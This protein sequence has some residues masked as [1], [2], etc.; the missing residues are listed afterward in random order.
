MAFVWVIR[1][2]CGLTDSRGHLSSTFSLSRD[3]PVHARFVRRERH[4]LRVACVVSTSKEMARDSQFLVAK[5]RGGCAL[6][7]CRFWCVTM[8]RWIL[9]PDW[10]AL[11]RK[12]TIKKICESTRHNEAAFQNIRRQLHVEHKITTLEKTYAPQGFY[13]PHNN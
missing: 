2:C 3:V 1:F 13:I 11:Q 5:W 8:A 4:T 9:C 7:L 6:F 10:R 12:S